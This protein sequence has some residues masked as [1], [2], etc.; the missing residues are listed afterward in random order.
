MP[1]LSPHYHVGIVVA[2]LPS[3]RRRFSELL[4]VTWGPVVR[5]ADTACR[6]GDGV[7][8][9]LPITFCYSTGTPSIELIEEAPGSIWVRNDHS[10][11]HHIGFWSDQLADHSGTLAA[12]GCPLQLCGREGEG[13][14][15]MFAYHGF[16]D[17]GVRVE[18]VDG[19]LRDTMAFFF[20][21]DP[22]AG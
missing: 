13:A 16:G 7:D 10:N 2:D 8:L 6:D 15:A 4:G 17:L 14:P 18:L 11:I 5:L 20:E 12:A 9:T 1:A 21:P 22:G 19:G 3:A